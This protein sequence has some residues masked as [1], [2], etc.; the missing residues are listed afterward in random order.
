MKPLL[1]MLH[2]GVRTGLRQEI[3]QNHAMVM[4]D[5]TIFGSTGTIFGCLFYIG[6][7][8]FMP[9]DQSQDNHMIYL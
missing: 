6:K 9:S 3:G 8:H 1:H 7:D 5:S 4:K 2:N